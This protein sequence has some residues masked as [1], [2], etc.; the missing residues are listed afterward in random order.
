MFSI[1]ITKRN[2][3]A[4]APTYITI[5][6]NGIK[7]TCKSS[8]LPVA[9]KKDK[10]KNRTL[11]TGLF[12]DMTAIEDNIQKLEKL[13][14]NNEVANIGHEIYLV[15]LTP[16]K[17]LELFRLVTPVKSNLP[18]IAVYPTPVKSLA[19]LCLTKTVE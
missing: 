12:D 6:D 19:P 7:S 9:L 4:I 14:K 5:K 13:I 2:K 15:S 8:K 16:Y 10:T 18:L 17:L 11:Y 1:I 3:T